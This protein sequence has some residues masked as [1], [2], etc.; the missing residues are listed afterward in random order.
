M[1]KRPQR[2]NPNAPLIDATKD[3]VLTVTAADIKGASRKDQNECAAAHALCRQGHF[4]SAQVHKGR[5]YIEQ[6]NGMWLRYMTPD[7]LHKEL[8]IFDRGGRMEPGD[9]ILKAPKGVQ[10]LGAH[11]KPKGRGGQTGRPP[12]KIHVIENVRADAPRGR[13]LFKRLMGDA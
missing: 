13:N 5:T 9:F 10:R 12:R 11:A 8:L 4:R 6:R 1:A 3:L 2:P 7:D